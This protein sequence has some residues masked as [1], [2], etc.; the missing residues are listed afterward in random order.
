MAKRKKL[1][2]EHMSKQE[3]EDFDKLY[4]FVQHDVLGYDK[5]RSLPR[6]YVLRLKGMKSSKYIENKSAKS[7]SDYSFE[8]IL[9][10]FK[11]CMADI[12][13][14]FASNS[15]R[16]EAHKFNY[17]MKIVENNLNTVCLK[18]EKMKRASDEIKNADMSDSYNY[19]NT[20]KPKKNDKKKNKF[21]D[22]W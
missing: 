18:I 10:T 19:V 4:K 9:L 5:K 12:R 21:N 17:A 14:G 3:Q 1:P 15:F 7:R 6:D 8:E 11:Y 13:S 22:L 20:F 16:D 2:V